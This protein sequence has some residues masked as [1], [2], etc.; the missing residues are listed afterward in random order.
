MIPFLIPAAVVIGVGGLITWAYNADKRNEKIRQ[1]MERIEKE[2][3]AYLDAR[4]IKKPVELVSANYHGKKY[5][6]V[7]EIKDI[8]T[9]YFR[10]KERAENELKELARLAG[11]NIV[12]NVKANRSEDCSGNYYYSIWSF[13]GKACKTDIF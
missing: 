11:C 3:E 2:R 8:E 13:S 4:N 10:K 9:D 5:K 1:E 12:L 6:N 7:I